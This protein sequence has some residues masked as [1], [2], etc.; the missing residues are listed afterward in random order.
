MYG[1]YDGPRG[2]LGLKGQCHKIKKK[3]LK[4]YDV[5]CVF[6]DEPLMVFKSLFCLAIFY[7]KTK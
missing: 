4:V 6:S 7:L 2:S 5:E 1:T 3:Y